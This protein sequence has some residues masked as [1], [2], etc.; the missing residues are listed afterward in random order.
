MRGDKKLTIKYGSVLIYNNF[1][2]CENEVANFKKLIEGN[3]TRKEDYMLNNGNN[4]KCKNTEIKTDYTVL[5][6]DAVEIVWIDNSIS[7]ISNIDDFPGYLI[8][9]VPIDEFE[10]REVDENMLYE[11]DI[12]SS[13]GWKNALVKQKDVRIENNS[14]R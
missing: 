12:C 13:F 4:K 8:Q 9:Y 5:S 11:R 14:Y 10:Q 3:E 6:Y 2:L 1:R 7:N